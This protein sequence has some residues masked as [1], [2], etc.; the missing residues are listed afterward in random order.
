MSEAVVVGVRVRPFD[1]RERSLGATLCIHMKGPTTSLSNPNYELWG[2]REGKQTFSFD[3]SFWSHDGYEVDERG[4]YCAAEGS[5]Y[6]DQRFVFEKFGERVL[7]NAFKGYHCCLFAYGQTGSGKSYSMVG[8]GAN[9]GIVPISCE[10]IFRRMDANE[11]KDL[12]FEVFISM[13]EIYKEAVQDLFLPPQDRPKGGLPIRESKAL[14][15]YVD[16]TQK[17]WV[18]SYMEIEAA[19]SDA[20]ENRTVGSTMM[21]STSSRAHTVTTIEFKQTQRIRDGASSSKFSLI[22]LVDLAGSEKAN[23]TGAAGNTFKEG[24]A[25]NKSLATLANVIEKLAERAEKTHADDRFAARKLQCAKQAT[26]VHIPYRQSKLTRLLQNALG[27]SSKTIMICALSPA[28]TNY[29]DTLSTLRYANRAKKVKTTA[30]VNDNPKEK[31]MRELKEENA[32]LQEMIQLLTNQ[33]YN[34]GEVK[35]VVSKQTEIDRLER[36]LKEL[37]TSAEQRILAAREQAFMEATGR[38]SGRYSRRR[39]YGSFQQSSSSGCPQL[40][41]LNKDMQLAGKLRF[42]LRENRVTR[43]GRMPEEDEE[44]EE[45]DDDDGATAAAVRTSNGGDTKQ[46]DAHGREVAPLEECVGREDELGSASQAEKHDQEEDTQRRRGGSE[47]NVE[48]EY[49]GLSSSGFVLCDENEDLP[50]EIVI[51][52]PGVLRKHAHIINNAGQCRLYCHAAARGTTWVNGVP[53]DTL[54]TQR[55]SEKRG[56]ASQDTNGDLISVPLAHKDRVT[57]GR[58]VFV[59]VD[60]SVEQA[61]VLIES[62]V[63]SYSRARKE[64]PAEWHTLADHQREAGR[65]NRGR[66]ATR[67][68]SLRSTGTWCSSACSDECC[69]CAAKD[70]KI[71]GLQK[72]LKSLQALVASIGPWDDEGEDAY[73]V[74][75]HDM[76]LGGAYGLDRLE[77]SMSAP[78]SRSDGLAASAA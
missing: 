47:G 11:E 9:K 73:N 39:S 65:R 14:G 1:D 37:E 44:E 10:E 23:Q 43:V 8:Q 51:G 25:I 41:N 15:I 64:L 52:G 7:D 69:E 72:Q 28:S 29:E 21:N 57:F 77:R 63:V 49:A 38:K 75:S 36:A 22:N 45:D 16:G 58:S 76:R 71:Q 67:R 53:F 50:P 48:E 78:A 70:R 46:N 62:G 4:Y 35:D 27:G 6:A 74:A 34:A 26:D 17:R 24:I 40:C 12:N 55:S 30:V 61:D 33:A 32:K 42:D 20:T 13:V 56:G 2:S 18:S 66:P 19:V 54:L 59:F 60:S 3:Q 31:I 5:R 68:G